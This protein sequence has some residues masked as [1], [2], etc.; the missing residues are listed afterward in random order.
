[1]GIAAGP[2]LNSKWVEAYSRVGFD[3][4]TYATVRSAFRPA[5]GLPNIR[6]VQNRDQFAIATRRTLS[7]GAVTIAVSTGI[8]SME[9]D[10]W[11][12]DVR[13]A[14]ERLGPGQILV[15]SVVGTPGTEGDYEALVSDYAQCAGWAAAAGA[16]VIE[17]HLACPD[18]FTEHLR[19]IY[20]NPPLSAHILYRVRTTVSVPVI[21]KLGLFRTPRLLHE[22]ANKLA[23]WASGFVMVHGLPRRVVDETGNSVFEASGRDLPYVVGSETYPVASRQV[24]ELLAWRK[25]G[26][27][28]RA[29]LAAGGITTVERAETLLRDGADVALVATAA[30]SDPLFAVRF[31][32]ISGVSAA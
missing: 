6:P 18:P 25:A 5:L 28:D 29:V 32:Q 20:E 10:I 14:K 19:M 8:P 23:P 17:V 9:P 3:V 16:D 27:W 15:V 26:A 31:R 24:L 11:R 2:L 12:R 7:N 1:V 22:T 13:R 21:A 4:L 30:L